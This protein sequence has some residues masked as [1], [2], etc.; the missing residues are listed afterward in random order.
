MFL[1]RASSV[2]LVTTAFLGGTVA[3]SYVASSTN[4]RIQSDS[5]NVGGILST[6]SSY[7]LEDTVGEVKS[8]TSSSLTY[9]V[10]SGY[11]QMQEIYLAVSPPG[12]ITMSPSIPSTGGGIANG[13]A[14]WTIITDNPAGYTASIRASTSPALVSGSNSFADYTPS[15]ANPDFAFSVPATTAEFGFSPEGPDVAQR[16]LDDG[17]TCNTGS[18]ETTDR[19]WDGLSTSATVIAVRPNANHPSGT[20]LTVKFR[21]ESGASN[22]QPAGNYRATTTMTILPR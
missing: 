8:G 15:G 16:Y 9:R 4:Y 19:C 10:R 1:V 7:R 14:T 17:A 11:Q 21:A 18:S 3:L 5:I 12:N 20:A 22:V 13:Q 2:L 6:S